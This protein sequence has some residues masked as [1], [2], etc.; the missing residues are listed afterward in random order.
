MFA[1]QKSYTKIILMQ[2]FCFSKLFLEQSFNKSVSY[3]IPLNTDRKGKA[4]SAIY[5][6]WFG[7]NCIYY[8]KFSVVLFWTQSQHYGKFSVVLFWTQSQHLYCQ[9]H[10]IS[11]ENETFKEWRCTKKVPSH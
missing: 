11:E 1:A 6:L 5:M 4:N 9:T 8:G 7:F 10:S 2:E 3:K